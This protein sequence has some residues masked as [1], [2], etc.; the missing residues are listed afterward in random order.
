MIVAR[1]LKDKGRNVITATPDTPMAEVTRLLTDNRIGALAICDN[2]ALI[3]IISERDIVTA[4]SAHGAAIMQEPAS[5]HM[6]KEVVTCTEQ[7]TVHHLMEDMTTHRF[8]HIPV[9]ENGKLTGIVSI[10]DV[11]K[12]RLALIEMEAESMRDYIKTG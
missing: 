1:I 4:L 2:D 3:G 7:D 5:R 9:V 11:V 12:L 8:R 10:G 6:T